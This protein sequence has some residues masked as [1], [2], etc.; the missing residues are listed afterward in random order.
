MSTITIPTMPATDCPSWC[1]SDHAEKWAESVARIGNVY[2]IPQLDGTMTEPR[3]WTAEDAL[4]T[5]TEVNARAH[6]VR[7][8]ST[9]TLDAAEVLV[10]DLTKC[11]DDLCLY[12]DGAGSITAEQARA[13][14]AA[15]VAGA[16]RLEAEQQRAALVDQAVREIVAAEGTQAVDR[17]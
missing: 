9:P 1:A 15:L 14:A 12:V 6:N 3:T 10:V 11:G 7:L 4:Q 13:F 8:S 2:S 17:G 5:W 16:D